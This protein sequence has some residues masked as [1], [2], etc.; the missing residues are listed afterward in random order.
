MFFPPPHLSLVQKFGIDKADIPD[1]ARVRRTASLTL[2]FVFL[3]CRGWEWIRVTFQISLRYFVRFFFVFIILCLVVVVAFTFSWF[4]C[5][6]RFHF[7]FSSFSY[8]FSFITLS[9][10]PFLSFHCGRSIKITFVICVQAPSS[11]LEALE[12][13][14]ANL[15]GRKPGSNATTPTGASA[16]RCVSRK[17]RAGRIMQS[18]SHCS[19][20]HEHTVHTRF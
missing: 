16:G 20:Y 5:L 1:L 2:F 11:L 19:R 15:E 4:V 10:P 3:F 6:Q 9:F 12:A 17:H 8:R 18:Q 7:S 14:L 13:H